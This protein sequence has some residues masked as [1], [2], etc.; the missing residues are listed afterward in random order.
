MECSSASSPTSL[1][2]VG[3]VIALVFIIL[4]L[5]KF[6]IITKEKLKSLKIPEFR[7]NQKT[8]AI[9][10][11]IG[12]LAQIVPVLAALNLPFSEWFKNS[13]GFL[14]YISLPVTVNTPCIPVGGVSDLPRWGRG[15][16]SFVLMWLVVGLI[17]YAGPLVRFATMGK[18]EVTAQQRANLQIIAAF[19]VTQ[20]TLVILPM[21]TSVSAFAADF[22]V[23]SANSIA[24]GVVVG[25]TY[26]VISK[27]GQIY[28][29]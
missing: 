11:Q 13:T 4:I 25:V 7:L 3:I 18:K 20:S 1:M 9:L 17:A 19:F 24:A 26:F 5:F 29:N 10:K 16:M 22:Y 6:N 2:F 23:G 28:K 12:S 14:E 21:L 15:L 8:Q 27:S